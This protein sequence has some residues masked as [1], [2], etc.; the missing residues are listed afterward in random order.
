MP[1]LSDPPALFAEWRT[2]VVAHGCRG[3]AAH[4]ARYVAALR[5]HGLTHFLT[6][7]VADF[8]RFPGVTVLDPAAVAA[9]PSP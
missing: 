8:T 1:L 7:N 5:G 6:F 9:P 4:D 3:K 2:L